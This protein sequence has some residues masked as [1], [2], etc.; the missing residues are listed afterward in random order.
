M[1]F[2][3]AALLE[4]AWILHGKFHKKTVVDVKNERDKRCAH[5]L[6]K[7]MIIIFPVCFS[8]F[9]ALFWTIMYKKEDFVFSD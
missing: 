8:V 5:P 2:I 1:D 4:Y 3:V 9:G 7:L 6:D